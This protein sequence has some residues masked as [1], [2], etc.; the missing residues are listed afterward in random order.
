M[1]DASH[2]HRLSQFGFECVCVG[3]GESS[4]EPLPFPWP[5]R[6][7]YVLCTSGSTGRPKATCFDHR[8]LSRVASWQTLRSGAFEGM[9][10]AQFSVLPFDVSLQELFSTW[11]SGGTL[12]VVP[13]SV[14]TDGAALI[15]FLRAE[16]IERLFIPIAVLTALAQSAAETSVDGLPLREVICG[17]DTML[18]SEPL[19]ALFRQ[20]PGC[21]LDTIRP[22]ETHGVTAF[23]EWRSGHGPASSDRHAGRGRPRLC[24]TTTWLVARAR[25]ARSS[26]L[27]GVARDTSGALT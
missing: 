12:I 26:W 5:D 8:A 7:S 14:R 23:R 16:R 13:P 18:L 2:A 1:T 21:T 15:A 9:R 25:W 4:P 27:A 11:S 20:L 10:T 19:V 6:L 17:G 22:T 24:S 3:G